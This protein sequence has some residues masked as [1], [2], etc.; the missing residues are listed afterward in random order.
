MRDF[1]SCHHIISQNMK[2]VNENKRSINENK[3]HPKLSTVLEN[4]EEEW[5]ERVEKET[6]NHFTK[7]PSMLKKFKV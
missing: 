1:V 3:R 7:C 5:K 2:I 6:A 4:T